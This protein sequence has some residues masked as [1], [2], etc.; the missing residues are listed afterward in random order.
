M[1]DISLADPSLPGLLSWSTVAKYN[2]R[3]HDAYVPGV[4]YDNILLL[5]LALEGRG[6]RLKDVIFTIQSRVLRGSKGREA[7]AQIKAEVTP[8]LAKNLIVV[9]LVAMNIPGVDVLVYQSFDRNP[10]AYEFKSVL[11]DV[12]YAL[13]AVDQSFHVEGVNM[14]GAATQR[15]VYAAAGRSPMRPATG[16]EVDL[17][18]DMG[19][20]V[21]KVVRSTT[22]KKRRV[23]LQLPCGRLLAVRLSAA[24]SIW[25]R[26]NPVG[27]MARGRGA[28]KHTDFTP[29][30]W[31][32]M[33]VAINMK[34]LTEPMI[35]LC[36]DSFL[37][38]DQHNDPIFHDAHEKMDGWHLLAT[39]FSKIIPIMNTYMAVGIEN[40]EE[41]RVLC[42]FHDWF[43]DQ[44]CAAIAREKALLNM[45]ALPVGAPPSTEDKASQKLHVSFF[46]PQCCDDL[47]MGIFGIVNMIYRTTE[48]D[49]LSPRRSIIMAKNTQDNVENMFGDIN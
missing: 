43:Y 16:R 39:K 10:H 34:F 24:E 36:E 7:M 20:A 1:S 23:K 8:M 22:S 28:F 30:S 3:R 4:Q 17:L 6:I 26:L 41:I 40:T 9:R 15:N 18:L 31:S 46:T 32:Q 45:P 33:K 27:A 37:Q 21:K 12:L 2:K 48:A 35:L 14:D 47:L 42:E 25:S 49:K 38:N 19:H 29:N 13:A 11:T 44:R 5:K